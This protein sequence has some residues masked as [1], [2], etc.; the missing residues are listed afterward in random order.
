MLKIL[1]QHNRHFSE[2]ADEA[3]DFRLGGQSRLDASVARTAA[4]DPACVK[5]HTSAKCRKYNSPTRYRTSCTQH[6][7][8][9]CCA[10]SSRCFYVRAGAGVF[11]QPRPLA[12]IGGIEIPQCSGSLLPWLRC[13]NLSVE[14]ARKESGSEPA[15]GHHT[16]RRR[17]D[18][19]AARCTCAAGTDA[20]HR[21]LDDDCCG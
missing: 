8:T 5:T 2:V 20:A 13:A 11:A 3:S 7:S 6:D 9:P 19:L 4:F 18:R 16:A 10:I 12:V 15:L 1:L 17:G 14:K 21:R